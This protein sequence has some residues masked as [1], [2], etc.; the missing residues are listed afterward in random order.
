MDKTRLW[1][2]GSVLVMVVLAALGW[3]VGIQPQLD[4]STAADAQTAQVE[5]S[6]M[7]SQ[8][9]LTKLKKDNGA[10]PE[11]KSQLGSLQTSIPAE[12]QTPA[13]M[14]EL[15]ALASANGLTVIASQIT[16]GAGF[17]PPVNPAAQAPAATSS[18]S[19]STATP[20]PS[21]TPTPS[22]APAPTATPT[23]VPGM[24]PAVSTLV[25]KD[26]FTV[27][28]VSITVRG[29]YPNIVAFVAAAQKGN[30]LFMVNGIN[31]GPAANGP[32]FDSKVS[33]LIYVL[34]T[35]AQTA[36]AK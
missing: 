3:V 20:T 11:L 16:D 32:G 6:N 25:S 28:P 26:D 8:A 19:G 2:I 1:I 15:N 9:V 23:A 36:P 18:G 34:K 10:L 24:P 27:I 33:G 35:G 22:V 12:A 5:S 31:V 14:D 17:V 29:N 13:F 7:A 30:R 4:Q 21:P